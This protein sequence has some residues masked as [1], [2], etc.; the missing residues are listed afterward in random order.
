MTIDNLRHLVRLRS[1]DDSEY[2]LPGALDGVL[3]NANHLEHRPAQTIQAVVN[4]N[5]PFLIDPMLWR[6]Q[7]P[8]WWQRTDGQVKRNFEKLGVLYRATWE[9]GSVCN[10]S[11]S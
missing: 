11:L 6:F 3:I 10:Q 5:I 7:V 8:R 2:L 4:R 9:P 1:D